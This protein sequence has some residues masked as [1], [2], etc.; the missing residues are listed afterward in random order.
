[1]ATSVAVG[2]VEFLELYVILANVPVFGGLD[3]SQAAPLVFALANAGFALAEFVFGQ[4][5]TMSTC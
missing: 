3:L 2:L 5:D 1:M 4:L